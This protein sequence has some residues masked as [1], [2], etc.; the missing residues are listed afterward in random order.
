[1]RRWEKARAGGM[2]RFVLLRGVLSY[3]LTMFVLMTFIVQRDDL[4]ARFIAI[5][6]LLWSVGGAVFG[7]L[8][9]FLMERI[10]R[11]FVPKIMA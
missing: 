3:G 2:T 1:M 6:A 8:T 5:S 11:K 4:S 9:W 10:Y 7:A